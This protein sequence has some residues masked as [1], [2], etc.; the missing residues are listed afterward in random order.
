VIGVQVVPRQLGELAVGQ[1]L[2][3]HV[4]GGRIAR[5]RIEIH[6]A[7]EQTRR[8]DELIEDLAVGVDGRAVIGAPGMA[9]QSRHKSMDVLRSYVRDSEPFRDHAGAGFYSLD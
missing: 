3:F 4:A 8:A 9:D 1:V 2:R 6:D 5:R 7:I